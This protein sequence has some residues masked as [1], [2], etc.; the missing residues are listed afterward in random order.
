MVF[1]LLMT[2][3][4]VFMSTDPFQDFITVYQWCKLNQF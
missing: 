1:L 3:N 4:Q 2:E